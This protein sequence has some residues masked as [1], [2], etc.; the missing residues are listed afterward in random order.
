MLSEAGLYVSTGK[1]YGKTG[2]G[3]IRIN[4]ACPRE[5]LEDGLTHLKKGIELFKKVSG[6]K[7][8]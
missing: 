7:R 2:R 8:F 1:V 4:M 3:F 5:R 6:N